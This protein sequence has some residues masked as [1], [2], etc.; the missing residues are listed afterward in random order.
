[1][2]KVMFRFLGAGLWDGDD[3]YPDPVPVPRVPIKGEKISLP[4]VSGWWEV[5]N[6]EF[7]YSAGLALE[8]VVGVYHA[9]PFYVEAKSP[10]RA[11]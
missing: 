9:Y 10:G 2:Q 6:V 7:D 5:A 11:G 8:P 1:M 3:V 4:E